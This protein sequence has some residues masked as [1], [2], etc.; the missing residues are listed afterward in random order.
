MDEDAK[1]E[2]LSLKHQSIEQTIEEELGHAAVD[3]IRVAELKKQKLQIKDEI[4][5]I[6]D[7][8]A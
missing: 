2:K 1:I 7:A 4:R 5:R 8:A 3:S 6:E